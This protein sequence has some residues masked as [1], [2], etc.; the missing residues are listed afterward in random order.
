MT[1]GTA[2]QTTLIA[3]QF[4]RRAPP[5]SQDIAA[6]NNN[7]LNDLNPSHPPWPGAFARTGLL[8]VPNRGVLQCLPGDYVA[9]DP[10]TGFPILISANAAAGASWIHT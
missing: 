3:V 7:I 6:I 10:A 2:A 9:I 5:T 8:F 4:N 1:L